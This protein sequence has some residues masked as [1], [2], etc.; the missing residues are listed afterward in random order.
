MSFL[1]WQKSVGLTF[2]ELPIF[3]STIDNNMSNINFAKVALIFCLGTS[4]HV[5]GQIFEKI[6]ENIEANFYVKKGSLKR[7]GTTVDF[8]QVTDYKDARTNKKG[9]SYKSMEMH[10]LLDCTQLKQN[11]VYMKVYSLNMATGNLIASGSMNQKND[12]PIGSTLEVI[13]NYVCR[14]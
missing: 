12:I 11:L 10:V 5:Y 8:W 2:P 14:G 4:S 6:A 1:L 13:K 7:A 9:E 3:D